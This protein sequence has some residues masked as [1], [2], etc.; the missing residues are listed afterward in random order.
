M[1]TGSP[2]DFS[3]PGIDGSP[4]I[5]VLIVN[6][7]SGA[8][9][10]ACLECLSGQTWRN[11]ETIVVD[12]AS[13]DGSERAAEEQGAGVTLIAAGANLGFAAGN[14]LGAREARGEWIAFL[15]PDAY[16]EPDWLAEF[17][18]ATRRYPWADA[19][20]STQIDAA[21]PQRIDG[22]GD[23]YHVFGI[24][25]RGHYGWPLA[26]L[27][28]DGECFAPCAAAAFYRR[29]MFERLGGFDERFFCYSEDVDLGFR[30]RLA[31]GRAV[32]LSAARVRHEG[33]GVT[34]RY[35]DFTVYHGNRNR[36]WTWWKNMPGIVLWPLLPAQ[37]FVSFYLMLRS[38]TVGIGPSY[39]RAMRDGYGGLRQF[40]ADRRRLQADRRVRLIDL[41]R[42]LTWS[43][44][45]V[46]RRQ[47]DLKPIR[48][49]DRQD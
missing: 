3:A 11:F 20:G 42:A 26:Q 37:L 47:A 36:I 27:P 30:L 44:L 49:A 10:R 32:Q 43:P 2:H 28:P 35:S 19:F 25:Y 8:R 41:A 31:G 34:G 48:R 46:S 1:P 12:N 14:N 17:V 15:N 18:A 22:A 23:V 16:A 39:R 6:Y 45:K 38:Y 21:D 9:L 5:T 7:N 4:L 33:S 29:E 40:S 24:A 13:I